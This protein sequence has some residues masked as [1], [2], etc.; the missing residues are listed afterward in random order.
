MSKSTNGTMTSSDIDFQMVAVLVEKI[1]VMKPDVI[2]I[3]NIE[4]AKSVSLKFLA[5][6]SLDVLQLAMEIEETFGME[7]DVVDFPPEMTVEGLAA[8]LV[9]LKKHQAES[10]R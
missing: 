8:Q 10:K 1:L 9:T 2:G 6:D 3:L 5:L 7:I 4:T